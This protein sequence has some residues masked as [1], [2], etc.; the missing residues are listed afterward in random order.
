MNAIVLVTT[1]NGMFGG[2]LVT[3]LAGDP[4]VAVRA[5]VRHEPKDP[6]SASNVSYVTGNLDDPDS[7]ARAV[8]GVTHVFLVSPMDEHV[9][10]REINMIDAAAAA[11]SRPHVVKIYGA[12]NHRGDRLASLHEQSIER[13]KASG[14]TW[15]LVSPNS[16]METALSS[17]AGTIKFDAIF[18]MSGH[19]RI[20]FVALEDVARLTAAVIRGDEGAGENLLVTGPAALDMYQVANAFSKALGRTIH[21]R[22]MPEDQ[23]GAMFLEWGV[24]P[25][26]EALEVGVLCHYRAWGRGDTDLV[27]D[28][29]RRITGRDPISV[30]DWIDRN[31]D[32]FNV[33]QTE[34]DRQAAAGIAAQFG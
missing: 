24:F 2:A 8:E 26:Q 18:G 10:T 32:R 12:V 6:A 7:L 23:L 31:L 27:T 22:D 19:G 16:V 15:T 5:M 29:C 11:D 9:A 21:Y 1:G 4:E 25:N 34:A 28:T 14:L 33:P 3:E 17:L 30:T 20:G 13:L